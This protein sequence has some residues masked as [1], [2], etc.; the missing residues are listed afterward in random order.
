MERKL[1]ANWEYEEILADI[2]KLR[3]ANPVK[4]LSEMLGYKPSNVSI[5]LN[6]KRRPSKQFVLKFY[7][8]FGKALI[9]IEKASNSCSSQNAILYLECI[10]RDKKIAEL[11]MSL[12]WLMSSNANNISNQTIR[13]V[14]HS[15]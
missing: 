7:E 11:E 12:K 6:R 14:V 15:S 10:K 5:F 2:E 8:V 13:S 4:N 9:N 1:N 3:L